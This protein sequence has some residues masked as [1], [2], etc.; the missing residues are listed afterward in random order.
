LELFHS[1]LRQD[2]RVVFGPSYGLFDSQGHDSHS[3]ILT[4]PSLSKDRDN[5]AF[6]PPHTRKSSIQFALEFHSNKMSAIRPLRI[7]SAA[8]VGATAGYGASHYWNTSFFQFTTVHAESPPSDAQAALKKMAWKGF[9]ELKLEK[10]EMVN[11]NVKKLTFALPDDQSI[12]GV[13]PVSM[14]KAARRLG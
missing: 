6:L 10:A 9:T 14:C 12:T 2:F 7:A 13:T 11:H 1:A 5:I 3:P 4:A 8:A